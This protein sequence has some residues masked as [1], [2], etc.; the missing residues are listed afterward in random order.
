MARLTGPR[1]CS[2]FEHR[3]TNLD[4]VLP[5][6]GS[7]DTSLT[8]APP[9]PPA[10]MPRWEAYAVQ[11]LRAA[12]AS[13]RTLYGARVCSPADF[14][15]AVD[16]DG[17]GA[18][19]AAEFQTA[20]ERLDVALTAEQLQVLFETM[21]A[22]HSGQLSYGELLAELGGSVQELTGVEAVGQAA[23]EPA[24]AGS[25]EGAGAD[26]MQVEDIGE[27]A[28]AGAG[29]G[30]VPAEAVAAAEP[31]VETFAA[32]RATLSKEVEV[33]ITEAVT[34]DAANAAR[35]ALKGILGNELPAAAAAAEVRKPK[36][37]KGPYSLRSK[38]PAAPAM[39]TRSQLP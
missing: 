25:A 39:S 23:E 34:E 33:S 29:A 36:A 31:K 12:M 10:A 11:Q 1:T 2:W 13:E 6:S 3:N 15:K 9:D 17:S 35:S 20:L 22:D 14:F 27:D 5:E 8:E 26:S 21:D 18:V 19:D 37:Q 32:A 7:L 28:A 24:A 30:T 38:K 4:L 16:R